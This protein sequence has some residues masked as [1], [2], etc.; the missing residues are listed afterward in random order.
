MCITRGE[1]SDVKQHAIFRF[2]SAFMPMRATPN[3]IALMKI[4]AKKLEDFFFD[5]FFIWDILLV[6]ESTMSS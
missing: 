5:V 2:R 3:K 1:G 6:F 4:M